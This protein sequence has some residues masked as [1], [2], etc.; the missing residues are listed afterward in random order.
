MALEAAGAD[1]FFAPSSAVPGLAA[2]FFP[3]AARGVL[4]SSSL[5]LLSSLVEE[6]E[7]EEEDFF[8]VFLLAGGGCGPQTSTTFCFL[9]PFPFSLKVSF[10]P[11]LELVF[12]STDF[13]PFLDSSSSSELDEEEEEDSLDSWDVFGGIF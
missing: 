2:V 10:P 4:T 6:E 3:L 13:W 12:P 9:A 5:E 7:E 8:S 11:T 1:G